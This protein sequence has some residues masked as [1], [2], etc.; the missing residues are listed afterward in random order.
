MNKSDRQKHRDNDP[1]E[2]VDEFLAWTKGLGGN[3]LLYRGLADATWGVEASGYRRIKNPEGDPIPR[4]VFQNSI[5]RLLDNA[6]LQGFREKQ[7]KSFFDLELLAELQH[8]G[9]ATCLID[10]TASPLVALWFSCQE[11][12]E[13]DGKIVAMATGNIDEFSEVEYSSLDNDIA[14]FFEEEKLWKWSPKHQNNRIVAQNSIFVF[15]RGQIEEEYYNS[16]TVKSESKED[17][18]RELQD[19]FGIAEQYLFSDFTGYALVNSHNK[20]Y[21]HYSAD[22]YVHL[23]LAFSQRR[24][25]DKAIDYYSKA[26]EKNSQHAPA[27]YNRGNSRGDLYDHRGAILDYDKALQLN[28]QDAETYGNRGNARSDLGEYRKAILDYD[29]ALEINSQ[30]ADTY[31]NRG[32]AKSNLGEYQEAILDYDMAL[33]INPLFAEGYNNRGVTKSHLDD[34]RGAIVDYDKA[35]TINPQLPEPYC[36]R[37]NAKRTMGDYQG[38]IVDYDAALKINPLYA[39]AYYNRGLA[40]RA[41]GDKVGAGQDVSKAVELDPDLE[42]SRNN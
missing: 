27:Y 15:G 25:H 22:D 28:P 36:N 21:R 39:V 26:I 33:K 35:L 7:G 24:E 3:L 37:G 30:D 19:R 2:T 40:K 16:I 1:I 4:L 32:T 10:F 17:I 14:K 18:I 5:E 41:L 20:E 38:G 31:C 8:N 34:Y 6:S 23:G 11:G 12:R 29:M 9:A 42:P 13:K